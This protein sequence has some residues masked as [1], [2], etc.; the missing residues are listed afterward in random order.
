MTTDDTLLIAREHDRRQLR[1]AVANGELERVRWGAYRPALEETTGPAATRRLAVDRLGAVHRQL[2]ARHVFSHE[3]AAL[4]WDAP[5][6]RSPR[7]VNVLVPSRPSSRGAADI[8]RR[9]G[10][11][12]E[13]VELHGMPA[14]T[15]TRTVVDCALTL[16]PLD[17]LVIADWALR[18]GLRRQAA[19][20][21]LARP[22]RR[23]GTARARWVLENAD[24]GA[25][26]PWE[27]WIRYLSLRAGLPRP[28]TQ[29]PVEVDGRRY[30]VDLGWS[31]HRVLVEFDG[32]VKYV[33]GSFGDGYDADRARFED[34][35]R[36]DA[37]T[38]RLG[39]RPMRFT[40]KDGPDPAAATASL[41]RAFSP[42]VRRSLR[43]NPL[44]PLPDAP[45]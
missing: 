34:K 40:A 20:E 29:F 33:D 14:T 1:R 23:N 38:A 18:N 13:H 22:R 31:E 39:V 8:V 43:V 44:L 2:R 24:A 35:V 27:T 25:E 5:L 28:R 41:L 45:F 11:P 19:L 17:A 32:R 26:S 10:L 15:L 4:L 16:H 9:S 21:M 42:S 12:D 30:R 36:E 37:I 7:R 3:S 6:W